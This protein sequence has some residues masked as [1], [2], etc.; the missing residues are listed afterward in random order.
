M[1][2][3]AYIYPHAGDAVFVVHVRPRLIVATTERSL[4]GDVC[5]SQ[6]MGHRLTTDLPP[7]DSPEGALQPYGVQAAKYVCIIPPASDSSGSHGPAITHRGFAA[8]QPTS[9]RRY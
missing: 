5:R 3:L 9:Q 8:E 4:H 2:V 1:Q 7:P 6:H